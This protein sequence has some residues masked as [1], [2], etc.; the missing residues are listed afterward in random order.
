MEDFSDAPVSITEHKAEK[1]RDARLWTCRDA[2]VSALRDIDSGKKNPTMLV[3]LAVT[4]DANGDNKFNNYCA[5]G[6]SLELL[7][8]IEFSK[9]DMF[10][11]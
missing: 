6:G 5:G 3:I 4:K 7:G 10:V 2:L 9:L 11:G 1:E 8:L